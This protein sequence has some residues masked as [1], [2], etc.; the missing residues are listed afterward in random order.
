MTIRSETTV[1]IVLVNFR[2]T[3]DT[4]VAIEQLEALDWPSERLEIVVVENASGD[5]SLERLRALGDRIV[6]VESERNRGFAGGCN[7]GV[8]RSTG[9]VI[10]FL[11][12]DARPD[13][14]WISAAVDRFGESVDIGAV[15]SRVLDWDG[16]RVD[17]VGAALTWYGMGY[18]P[19]TG[20]RV[21]AAPAATNDVLF[22][23]GSAMFV[24]REVFDALGGFDESYFMFFEDVDFGWRLTLRGWRFAYA[25][26][27]LAYHKHHASMSSFGA[28]RERYLLERNA[29]FTL[30]KNLDD[31]QLRDRLPAAMALAVRRAVSRAGVDSTSLDIR[32]AAD[33]TDDRTVPAEVL[34]GTYAIDQ[35]VE[36]LPALT[37]ARSEI[38]AGRRVSDAALW[39]LFGI[40][41]VPAGEG[42]QYLD[43]Y[44]KV[45]DAFDVLGGPRATRVLVITGDP[46]GVKLA[47]P[48]IRAWNMADALSRTCDVT[49]VSLS[50]VDD[51]DAPFRL[52]HVRPRDDRAFA[53]LEADADVIIFQGHAMESFDTLRRSDKI[54]VID[55]YDPMHFEQL[56][57]ARGLGMTLW[58]KQVE[59]ATIVLNEQLARGDFFLCAS[60]RQRHLYLGQL[61]ALGRVTPTVYENDRDLTG[62]I[63]VVPFGISD[64]P[65]RHDRA[66]LKGIKPGI[67]VD[68]KVVLWGGGLYDWFDP[69]TLIRG[70]AILAQTRPDVRLFFQGTAH[71]HPGVPRMAIVAESIE[72]ARDLGVLDTVVFFNDSWVDFADRGNYL[73]EADA[74]VSTHHDHIETTFSFR[75]RI[76]DYLWAGLPMVVTEGDHFAEVVKREGLGVVVPEHDPEAI[77]AALEK[78]LYDDEF[79]ASARAAIARVAESY[80]WS[81]VLAPLLDFVRD[82]RPARDRAEGGSSAR[83]SGA[84]RAPRRRSGPVNDARLALFYLRN[85]G[86]RVVVDKIRNRVRRA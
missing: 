86:P 73:L 54:F 78:V 63:S 33:E 77:A 43:G 56:E 19:A 44:E 10:G 62:L 22:G 53:K 68:A 79:A 27:S 17:F 36:H 71:P 42:A 18:K 66:V 47:G 4:L 70:M 80:R 2:G 31:E 7:L 52:Q 23:T 11:N 82:L 28:Y 40:T 24:R 57:Q 35:F 76:L 1:S 6:L 69:Q 51:I 41:D 37:A 49:L 14:S 46:I 12:N 5:D 50:R 60:E 34:A 38:Q 8:A 48:A 84:V 58:T 85:G 16:E 13:P 29:L 67:A 75:T 81:S 39:S 61:A 55:V 59:E 83:T 9:S 30:F 65:P 3:D 72:L 74:G 64:V 20:D 45:V 32:S 26:G 15:A 21:A 25:P